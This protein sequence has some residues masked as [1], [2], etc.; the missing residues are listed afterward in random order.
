M[1]DFSVRSTAPRPKLVYILGAGR[2][3]STILGATLGNCEGFV[4]GGEL[5]YWLPRGGVPQSGS[6]AQERFWEQVRMHVDTEGLSGNEARMSLERSMSLLQPRRWRARGRLRDP[7]RR[8]CESLITA[9]ANVS[10]A[11]FV[12]DTSH[13]PLR[14]R[15]LQAI[16]G[17]ELYLIFLVRDPERVVASLDPADP[18]SYS[19][20]TLAANAYLWLTHALALR[21]FLRHPPERRLFLRFDT[22]L[23]HPHVVLRRVL[24]WLGTSA[25]VPDLQALSVGFPILAN[26]FTRASQTTALRQPAGPAKRSRLTE[27]L[28]LPWT[29]A[30][31][32]LWPAIEA[33]AEG[34][35]IREQA[36]R[37]RARPDP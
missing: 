13:Y 2:S 5:N 22:F 24:D 31:S 25:E 9:I 28:Q 15:E 21:V 32:R 17:I 16:E 7:Y 33:D 29:A 1:P 36:A 6:A 35:H 19:Q 20:S 11:S 23:A 37:V 14:A 8:F 4:Y 12:V 10:G 30:F 27:A 34:V 18:T 26:R 3:G